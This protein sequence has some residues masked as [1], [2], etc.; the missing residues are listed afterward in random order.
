MTGITYN[1]YATQSPSFSTITSPSTESPCPGLILIDTT[2]HK[3]LNLTPITINSYDAIV[4][5]GDWLFTVEGVSASGSRGE[6][7]PPV[8]KTVKGRPAKI[9]TFDA[10]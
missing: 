2:L 10:K 6:F 7:A 8:L 5:D 1:V 3:A 4:A 9:I